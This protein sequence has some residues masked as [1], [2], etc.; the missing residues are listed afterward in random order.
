MAERKIKISELDK[1]MASLPGSETPL[2]WHR[3]DGPPFRL[4][5]FPW[6]GQDR[7]YRRLPVDPCRGLPDAVDRLADCTAGGQVSFR[8]D[9]THL[10]I[11]VNLAGPANMN[12]MPAT[13]Q[14]GFD[15]YMGQPFVQRFHSVSKYDHTQ[16]A[17]E[18]L[19]FAHP[20]RDM[21]DFT[22]N[23]PLYQGV[24]Q[25]QVGLKPEAHIAPPLTWSTSKRIVI[26]GT[27]ITQG[28]CASRPGLAYTNI[29]SR[30][31]NV[32]VINLGFSG[33]GKGEPDVIR[34]MADVPDPQLLVLDYEANSG[35]ELDRTLPE[36]IRILR[37]RRIRVPILIVSRIAF[38][39]DATHIDSA[40]ARKSSRDMQSVL[41]ANARRK[42]DHNI[43]FLDGSVLLGA[44]FDEC[45]V[46]GVHPNDLGFMRIARQLEPK[47]QSILDMKQQSSRQ[48]Q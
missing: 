35:G 22:L 36:A 46:D 27:S 10:A 37:D 43:H 6:Y 32:E 28:G 21:R 30:A 45:T 9:S 41:V 5:G 25:L 14:C 18:L 15:L 38:A 47:I 3:P 34:L 7:V 4:S 16:T 31:L 1:H 39:R 12:H 23:F 24:K 11:R 33:N 42:G 17:Y 26:Y 20:E 13:G 44:D 19:L 8:S 48:S 40:Q 2:L 29:L